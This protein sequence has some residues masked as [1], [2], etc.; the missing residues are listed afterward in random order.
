MGEWNKPRQGTNCFMQY[1]PHTGAAKP[2]RG[3][4]AGCAERRKRANSAGTFLTFSATT[5]EPRRD[6][7]SDSDTAPHAFLAA[8]RARGRS[9]AM[10]LTYIWLNCCLKLACLMRNR[11]FIAE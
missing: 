3:D 5:G 10:R 7:A 6:D 4:A 9:L 11:W 2:G 8:A 1:S